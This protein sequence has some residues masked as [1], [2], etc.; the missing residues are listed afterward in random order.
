MGKTNEPPNPQPGFKELAIKALLCRDQWRLWAQR[1]PAGSVQARHA[2]HLANLF[3]RQAETLSG[4][5][6]NRT[7]LA[8]P[9]R[10]DFRR[11]Q[12]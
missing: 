12:R 4:M 2:H 8:A 1:E 11:Q 6:R 5:H 9:T 10:N 3:E 7:E